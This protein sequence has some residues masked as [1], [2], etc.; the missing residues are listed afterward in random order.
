M[1]KKIA[2]IGAGH[3][4]HAA[5]AEM[6]EK[7]H[8]VRLYQDE[9]YLNL[10]KKVYEEKKIKIS[11]ANRATAVVDIAVITSNLKEA[12]K[13]A[14]II[15]L[16]VPAF[17][18]RDLASQL[19][20][21]VEDEQVLAL[22]PGTLGSLV[23]ARIFR[24]KGVLDKVTIA[25]TNTLPYDTRVLA[26]GEVFVYCM[27]NPLL[28]GVFP[29]S[30]SSE[31]FKKLENTYNYRPVS[32]ILECALHS[33]NPILHTP[34]CIM[35]TGRI[36]RSKGEFYLYEEGFSPTV[37]RVTEEMDKERMA[38]ANAYGYN[39]LT[40][41]QALSGLEKPGTLWK[42]VNGN[43]GLCFIKGPESIDSRYFTEDTPNGLVPWSMLAKLAGVKTP[44]IDSFATI[45]S[46]VIKYDSWNNGRTLKDMG[47]D[48][49]SKEG[50]QEYLRIGKK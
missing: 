49:L 44:L 25:E 38:I 40:L 5:S 26:P 9:K 22:L 50:F 48:G 19:A 21:L 29:A 30:R 31:A 17:A 16:T 23:F 1:S 20:P 28:L 43:A 47:V 27:N 13:G 45:A 33:H 24:E 39:P 2:I 7:G 11:G 12:V 15:F 37:C 4:G 10:I 3:G 42:E 46:T 6:T 34:G 18:H 32:D 8:E 35:N 36:E 14:D 41:T